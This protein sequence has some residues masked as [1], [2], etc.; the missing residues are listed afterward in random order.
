MCILMYKYVVNIIYLLIFQSYIC[1]YIYNNQGKL[2]VLIAT[3]VAARGIHINRLKYVINY[4]FPLNLEQYCH[5][6]GRTGRQD[7]IG[8]AYSFLTRN[9]AMLSKD[10][11][12]LLQICKQVIEPNL[13]KLANDYEIGNII[14]GVYTT[15][16][17]QNDDDEEEDEDSND[18][19]ENDI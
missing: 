6:V 11:I 17:P 10:L 15:N 19:K 5:R 1:K 12:K 16:D 2:N 8:Y 4:D 14:D 7:S 13:I 9:L 3:D 18:I